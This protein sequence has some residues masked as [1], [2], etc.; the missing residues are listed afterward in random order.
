MGIPNGDDSTLAA[1]AEQHPDYQG[2]Q[3]RPSFLLAGTASVGSFAEMP[4]GLAR[5]LS[6][7]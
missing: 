2:K 4:G 5:A 1:T 7:V 6:L 3:E